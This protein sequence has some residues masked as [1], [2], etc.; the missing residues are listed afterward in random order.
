MLVV[1]SAALRFH[2]KPAAECAIRS[3]PRLQS[4]AKALAAELKNL[5]AKAIKKQ[6]HVND[7]LAKQ[8]SQAL[9]NFE[10]Q[11]PVPAIS[12]YDT[13]LYESFG[14][15]HF[16][17]DDA[18]WAN[19]YVR[20]FSGLYGL[21]RPFDQIAPLSLPVGLDTKLTTSKGKFLRDFWLE[22]VRQ[23]L[24]DS[25]QR[26]PMPVIINLAQEEDSVLLD[27]DALPDGT[28]IVTV[29]FKTIDKSETAPAKGEFVRWMLEER[30]MTVE[31]LLQFKGIVEDGQDAMFR[32]VPGGANPDELTFEENR[33]EGAA[34]GWSKK[35][36]EHGGSKKAFIRE[37]A[38][39]KDRYKR[40]EINKSL[41][42][43]DKKKRTKS[44]F[45]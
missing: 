6:L 23:E 34:G 1:L 5:D 3:A 37:F 21:I 17:Q 4:K 30:C 20:I 39:G 42:K 45:Y 25:V 18:D 14:C 7:A 19:Q 12:L 31:E 43:E 22:N 16:D 44:T 8:Y 33:G 36:S 38:R 27:R 10:K 29:N 28:R 15:A 9:L 24:Y 13:P 32:L 2:S 40:T 35:L 11:E 41:A 26:L